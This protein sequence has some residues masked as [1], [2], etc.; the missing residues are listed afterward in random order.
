[1]KKVVKLKEFGSSLGVT[2]NRLLG[3]RQLARAVGLEK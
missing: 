2:K 3:E 1:M